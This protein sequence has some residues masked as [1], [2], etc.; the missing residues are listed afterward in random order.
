MPIPCHLCG[1]CDTEEIRSRDRHGDPLRS[2]ICRRCGLVW[3]DPRPSPDEVRQFYERQYRVEYKGA[4]DPRPRQRYRNANV[5]ITRVRALREF[6]ER[7]ARMLDV[8]AGSGEMVYMLRAIGCNASGIEPNEAYARYAAESLKLPVTT[9]F[10]QDATIA[11]GTLDVVTMYHTVE[12]LEQPRDAMETAHRWLRPG[13]R[14]VVEVPNVEAVCQRPDQQFHRGHL[15]HFNLTTLA[16][17][18]NRAGF[19]VTV[20]WTS[21]DGGNIAIVATKSEAPVST[22]SDLS[23]NYVRVAHVLRSHTPWRH[24]LSRHPWVRPLRKLSARAD[25]YA[26]TFGTRSAEALLDEVL[27]RSGVTALPPRQAQPSASVSS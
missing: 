7:D 13:G 22:P 4:S 10:Y 9:G 1:V 12:H 24:L 8:G 5:A 16:A 18:A 14:L 19:N 23:S 25:E 2:V 11:S 6:L 15:H 26:H 21:P 20:R 17:A 27:G 3:T